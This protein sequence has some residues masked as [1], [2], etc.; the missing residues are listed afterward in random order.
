MRRF[1]TLFTVL[2]L[3]AALA[4]A[5]TQVVTGRITDENGNPVA[6]ASVQEKNSN[7]GTITD[8]EGNF[9]LSTTRGKTLVISNVGYE[10]IE[11][12]A[13]S[14]PINIS[15]KAGNQN[16]TEVVVTALGI[17]RD[18]KA[19]GYAVT[20]INK[21]QVELRPESDI[22]KILS[23]KV[24]G[25]DIGAT[26]GISGSGTNIVIRGLSSITGNSTPLF[27][28]D[29]APF[30]ASSN[31]QSNFLYNNQ[32][33]NRFLD[34]DPNNIESVSVLRGL[35]A[36]VLYG[37]AGRNGVI[38]ITT[39]SGA[40]RKVKSKA[41]IT[42]TQSNFVNEVANLPEYQNK[43]GGG[44][45]QSL[46]FQF[47]SNWGEEFKNPGTLVNHPQNSAGYALAFPEYQGVKTPFQAYPNN[48][49]DFFRKGF[50]NTS[51]VTVSASPSAN[52]N[53]SA[54]YTYYKDKGFV[55]GNDLMKNTLGIGG[56][57]KLT[58]NFTLNA[59]M[60]YATTDYQTPPNSASSGSGAFNGPSIFGDVIY[61]PRSINLTDWPSENPLTGGSVY[62][63]PTTS[64]QI[65]NPRWTAKY[66]KARENVQRVFGQTTLRYDITNN[67]NLTYRVGI[68]NYNNENSYQSPKGG[69][70]IPLGAY[71]TANIRSTIWSHLLAANYSTKFGSNFDLTV[72][73]GG[74]LGRDFYKQT[75]I[76]SSEQLAFN[77][78]N[79]NNFINHT[80]KGEDG[81]NLDFQSETETIAAFA[82]GTVGFKNFLY[83]TVGGR[84]S[85]VSTLEKK[86][87]HLFYPSGS[88][89]FIPTSA[90]SGLA[91]NK[92]INYTK[93]RLGYATSARFPDPYRTRPFL[94]IGSNVFVTPAGVQVNTNSI[95]NRLPNPDLKPELLK[96][97]EV[98]LEGKFIKNR[99][100]LD[101]TWY[102]RISNDQI[103]T[104]QLDPST[105]YTEKEINVGAVR[106]RGIEIGL[107]IT[108]FKSKSFSWDMNV[109]F[110][111]NRNMVTKLLAGTKEIPVA[112]FTNLGGFA[113]VGKPLGIMQGYYVQLDT[114]NVIPGSKK[115]GQR[116]V[117]NNGDYLSSTEIGIIGDPTPDFKVSM[118]NTFTYK[119]LGLHFQWDYTK[120]GD[121][122]SVTIGTLLGRG[123]SQ[124]VAT[125]DRKLP[126]VLPGVKQDGTTNDIQ[127]DLTNAYFNNY[128]FGPNSLRVFD[129]T[130]VRLKEVALSYDLPAKII[131]KTPFGG[132]SITLSGQN[133]WYKAPNVP[134]Y[135]HFDPETSGLGNNSYRGFEFITGPSSR[136]YGGSIKITF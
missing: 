11:V 29:G 129:A 72:N 109:N 87:N 134:K 12:S 116:I 28:I 74:N 58:N 47:F 105:G 1:L 79:H 17:K 81:S 10:R 59:T 126:I 82:E 66:V 48:V 56:G 51:S 78:F 36:T 106:N 73:A 119:G 108:P 7:K 3:S 14:S 80:N 15:L 107:G 64:S 37:E 61:T 19:L 21:D 25:V 117:D 88:I 94:N 136:R 42:L 62:Y 89:A 98:G 71:R 45:H 9:T 70:Q 50:I 132:V 38:L 123:V 5:Q 110:T 91:G 32:S 114:G 127:T 83:A 40:N 8:A 100:S 101:F 13:G 55:P 130:V 84:N 53:I 49:K 76:Y 112:G 99:I 4:S 125:L 85:W 95:P 60:N 39:K 6:R 67:F 115:T 68:D 121:I 34:I 52:T 43:Y 44:F 24:P 54:T 22:A 97:L 93:L 16:L 30:D 92:W 57:V 90:I 41:E 102:N 122:Y 135:T 65:Q 124:D 118:I 131:S 63:R 18:K 120:G 133:L 69:V 46:G 33:S 75:G 77:V 113:I 104:Q 2:M 86:N 31:A 96:E 111:R 103:V 27:I 20:T 23:G 26:S 128:G 35:S